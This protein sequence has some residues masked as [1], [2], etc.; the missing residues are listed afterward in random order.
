MTNGAVKNMFCCV[1]FA[2]MLFVCVIPYS[3]C[4]G[5]IDLLLGPNFLPSNCTCLLNTSL[6]PNDN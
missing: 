4:T 2:K 6:W 3:D 5:M 1:N